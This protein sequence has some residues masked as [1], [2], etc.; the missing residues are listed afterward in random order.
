MIT[1]WMTLGGNRAPGDNPLLFSWH[2]IF[3]MPSRIDKAGHTKAFDYPVAEHWAENRNVQP[4]EDSNRQHIG[5]QSN[6]LPTEPSRLPPE[7][8][9]TPGPQQ[10]DLLPTGGIV[11]KEQP[12][13]E[14]A[15]PIGP[16]IA[17]YPLKCVLKHADYWII[18]NR[19]R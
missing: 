17:W 8:H 19:K 11:G 1:G 13:H 15:I 5:S 14:K 4:R 10:G 12:R 2:W 6:A 18:V 7:D 3:H 9:I 16:R